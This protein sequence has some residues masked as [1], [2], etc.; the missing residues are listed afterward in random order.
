ME[1]ILITVTTVKI[2]LSK[3]DIRRITI[4]KNSS[5]LAF[6]SGRTVIK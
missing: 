3:E 6:A 4:F 2:K 1:F 5:Y